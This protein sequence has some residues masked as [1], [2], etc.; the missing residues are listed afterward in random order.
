MKPRN[1]QP[2]STFSPSSR[3]VVYLCTACDAPVSVSKDAVDR[4]CGHDGAGIRALLSATAT[5]EA[6]VAS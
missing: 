1:Q 3:P 4:P 2:Y 5:G 6:L